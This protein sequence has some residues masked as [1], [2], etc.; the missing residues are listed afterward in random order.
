MVR[1][2]VV[3]LMASAAVVAGGM[4]ALAPPLRAA[5]QSSIPSYDHVFV[6]VG[7]NHSFSDAI[8]NPVAPNLNALEKQFGLSTQ[9]F[10]VTHTSE[11]NYVALL[12]GSPFNVHSDAA[13]YTQQVAQ[14]T[15]SASWTARTSPGRRTCNRCR[16]RTTRRSAIRRT[17]TARRTRTRCT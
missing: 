7:E 9:C 3:A 5:G 16:T 6:I 13:Y 12:G 2:L 10:G 11:P 8:G 14:Q 15:S 4:A 17:A 1:R